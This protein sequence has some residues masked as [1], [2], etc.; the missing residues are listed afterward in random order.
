MA[1][2]GMDVLDMDQILEFLNHSRTE[3]EAIEAQL[4]A[5]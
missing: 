1:K 2:L 5:I 3:I 4:S